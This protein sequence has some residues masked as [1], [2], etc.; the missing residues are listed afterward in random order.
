MTPAPRTRL[1]ENLDS[2]EEIDGLE[3]RRNEPLSAYARFGIGGPADLFLSAATPEAL[4]AAIRAL[5]F[6]GIGWV[7]LG[8]GSNVIAADA[9]YRGAILRYVAETVEACGDHVYAETGAPLQ[10]LV[11]ATIDAG[12]A[13]LH[14]LERIPGWVG[15]AVYGNA[16][17]YGHQFDEMLVEATYLEDGAT[18]TA[19]NAGCEFAYRESVFKRE[20]RRIL[21]SCSLKLPAGD[22]KTLRAEADRIR[23]IRDAKF[24]PSMRCAGSIFKNLYLADLPHEAQALVPDRA[25]R[26]GKVASAFFL[27]L[28][29]AKG[30][31]RGGIRIADYHAN[32]I[33]NDGGGSS[34]D[35]YS[36]ISELKARV[37][38]RFGFELEEEVQYVGDVRGGA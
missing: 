26:A 8:G 14:T 23:E 2:L 1:D 28:A 27:E 15:G 11:N 18:K 6:E 13:G 32:L 17:A 34:A 24:P 4:T 16:G 29:G 7:V 25:V 36:V 3:V 37:R 33:Y 21:L 22:P 38:D 20:K 35:L 10:A 5:N 19:D 12:L 30:M 31:R 9:G